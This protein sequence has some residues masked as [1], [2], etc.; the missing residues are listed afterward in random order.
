MRL[1]Y[2]CTV[3][4]NSLLEMQE[5]NHEIINRIVR[6]IPC[7]VIASELAKVYFVF[8][9]TFDDDYC[10]EAFRRS[11]IK[12]S[13]EEP[14]NP[15]DE[16][17]IEYGFN[18]FILTNILMMRNPK[19][20]EAELEEVQN[21]IQNYQ[22]MEDRDD[23]VD[24]F[25]DLSNVLASGLGALKN[26]AGRESGGQS[27]VQ[28]ALEKIKLQNDAFKFFALNTGFIEVIRDQ[29]LQR[30]YFPILPECKMLPK[31]NKLNFHEYVDHTS[32]R[33]KLI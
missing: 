1:K 4:L 9:R 13:L 7:S 16:L 26:L 3:T 31:E 25:G 2:K 6:S 8:T 14:E 11:E 15:D 32:T 23:E 20:Q 24:L 27:E 18:L 5:N 22:F 17:V 29:Q 21:I 28:L 12:I 10:S 19:Q 30:L 33:E